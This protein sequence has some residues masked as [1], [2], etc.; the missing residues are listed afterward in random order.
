MSSLDEQLLQAAEDG[1]LD[2]VK[3]LVKEGANVNCKDLLERTPL[4]WAYRYD[5][6][7]TE[8]VSFL[9]S[10]G[11]GVNSKDD[12]G[13]TPLHVAC[14]YD[15]TETVSFL[16]SKG[17][18]VNAKDD[19][20]STPLHWACQYGCKATVS[21]LVSKGA[22]VNAKNN[23]GWTPLHVASEY[24]NTDAAFV[25]IKNG[26]DMSI[27]SHGGNTALD[28]AK[29]TDVAKALSSQT[30]QRQETHQDP[31]MAMAANHN[32]LNTEVIALSEQ[33]QKLV[34]EEEQKKSEMAVL[35]DKMK[36]DVAV[37]SEKHNHDIAAI[38]AVL[39]EVIQE[40][41]DLKA[42]I[43]KTRADAENVKAE[44][45]KQI[46]ALQD[47]RTK[48]DSELTRTIAKQA[49]DDRVFNLILKRKQLKDIGITESEIDDQL[50]LPG[51][52]EHE[53]LTKK[54]RL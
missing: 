51:K 7:D 23:K 3:R 37:L 13:W 30:E 5:L 17:A 42:A 4:H 19:K 2:E 27:K 43:V 20:C 54:Q 26:A 18:G 22:G 12:Q 29:N 53:P 49:N 9:V 52:D 33:Q 50:P 15:R 25:L 46:A 14:R 44:Q 40:N 21:F 16:Y 36:S 38:Q 32:K 35:E 48:V 31:T 24:G 1:E 47:E 41:K 8:A 39:D 45:G 34:R 11:A 28:V 6:M 10:K